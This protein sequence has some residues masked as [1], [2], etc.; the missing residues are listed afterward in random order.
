MLAQKSGDPAGMHEMKVLI[1]MLICM[2]CT[3]WSC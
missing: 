1:S 3:G 2:E